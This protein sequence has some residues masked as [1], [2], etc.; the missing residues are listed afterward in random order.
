MVWLGVVAVLVGGPVI[1]WVNHRI[2][3]RR[4]QLSTTEWRRLMRSLDNDSQNAGLRLI[5]KHK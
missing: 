5:E 3:A 4:K 2:H 1:A